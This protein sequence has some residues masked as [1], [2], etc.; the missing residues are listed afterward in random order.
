MATA[1]TVEKAPDWS[2]WVLD[3]EN[4]KSAYLSSWHRLKTQR[5]W[6]AANRP[7]LL[8]AHDKVMQSFRNQTDAIDNLQ[9]LNIQVGNFYRGLGVIG[10]WVTSAFDSVKNAVG[11]GEHMGAVPVVWVAVGIGSA[12][13]ALLAIIDVIKQGNEHAARIDATMKFQAEGA[14]PGEAA[15]AVNRIFGEP[16]RQEFLGIPFTT[17]ALAA[18]A[19]VLGP[20][21]IRMISKGRK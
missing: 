9:R 5:V 20:P 19:V 15:N 1:L 10:N 14:T 16:S 2:R 18:V 6:I 12:A 3:F 13:T 21:V 17:L 11:L 4:A 8:A 7:D